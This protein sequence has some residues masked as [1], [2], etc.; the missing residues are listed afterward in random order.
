M[1]TVKEAL[2]ALVDSGVAE[3]IKRTR[4]FGDE[5]VYRMVYDINWATAKTIQELVDMRR[6]RLKAASARTD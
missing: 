5:E 3:R 6:E 2:E 4:P 1:T